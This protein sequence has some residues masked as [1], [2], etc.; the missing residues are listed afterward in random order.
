MDNS[1][2][3]QDGQVSQHCVRTNLIKTAVRYEAS[4]QVEQ[5]RGFLNF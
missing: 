2:E 1:K 3:R 4:H 5:E